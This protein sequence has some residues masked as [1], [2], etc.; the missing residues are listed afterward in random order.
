M[1]EL[2]VANRRTKFVDFVVSLSRF[3]P[4]GRGTCFKVLLNLLGSPERILGTLDGQK[5]C[6]DIIDQDIAVRIY[7]WNEWEIPISALWVHLL[8][9]GMTVMDIGA[10]KG[11]FSL[12]AAKRIL[13]GGRLISY[14][15]HPRNLRDIQITLSSND[16]THWQAFEVAISSTEGVT[17]MATPGWD[18]GGSGWGSIERDDGPMIDVNTATL[19]G[20]ANRLDLNQIDLVKMDIEGHELS[21]ILG[22][23]TLLKN[24]SIRKLMMETHT[25]SLGQRIDDLF[26]LLI[27]YSYQ[28]KLVKEDALTKHQWKR[29]RDQRESFPE[30]KVLLPITLNEFKNSGLEGA[31]YILW[32][33]AEGR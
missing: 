3:L 29:V 19:D 18:E 33:P 22:A 4:K 5:F 26:N 31:P 7:L 9:P 1:K 15:P 21:A 14:E 2:T 30:E 12:L 27:D 25:R 28:P 13:N 11:Y 6:V 16:Y 32:E 17:K 24:Q 20:E 10:N 8:A 23:E